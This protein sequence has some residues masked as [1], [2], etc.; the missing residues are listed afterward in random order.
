M[1]RRDGALSF[2]S[3]GKAM[4]FHGDMD[5]MDVTVTVRAGSA[6]TT[7]V[8]PLDARDLER[9][10]EFLNSK[11]MARDAEAVKPDIRSE[12]ERVDAFMEGFRCARSSSATR[13]TC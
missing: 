1:L 11:R 6:R 8:Y 9:L 4:T 7:T 5:R 2:E 13:S 12:S 3:N 10:F